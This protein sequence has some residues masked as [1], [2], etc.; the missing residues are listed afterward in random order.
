MIVELAIIALIFV[1]AAATPLIF[2]SLMI[3]MIS[4]ILVNRPN[5]YDGWVYYGGLLEKARRYEN[6]ADALVTAVTLRPNLSEGSEKLGDVYAIL[7]DS[8]RAI[9]AYRLAAD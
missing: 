9:E 2:P 7:G 3:Q 8:E 1:F 6:A 5:D 4:R